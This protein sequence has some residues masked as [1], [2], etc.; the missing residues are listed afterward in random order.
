MTLSDNAEEIL[1]ALWTELVNRR[2][3][4]CD[5]ALLRD[6]AALQELVQ[7]GFVHVEN[8]RATLTQKGA[9]ESRNCVR[10]HRLAERLLTDVLNCRQSLIHEAGCRFEHLLRKGLE[11]NVCTL[12]GHPRYCP[13]GEPI[14][15]GRCC[16]EARALAEKIFLP[17][18]ELGLKQRAQ[19]AYVHTH[20]RESLEK[21][22]LVGLF[23]GVDVVLLERFPSF[24]LQMG[25]TQFVIDRTLASSVY[26]RRLGRDN[27]E[28]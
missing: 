25:Q 17:L 2:R 5:V 16:R 13:H 1:E 12:L 7:K 28:K 23:P 21:I 4:S 26:V 3:K 18:S 6:A 22:M 10:R 19:V 11:E 15:E 14:P 24:V 8:S 20:D 27:T 9:E